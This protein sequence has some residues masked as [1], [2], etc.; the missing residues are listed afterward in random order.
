MSD[1]SQDKQAKE[2][3]EAIMPSEAELKEAD[4]NVDIL[5]LTSGTLADGGDFY[6]YVAIPPSKYQAFL[7]AEQAGNYNLA[8]FGEIL[9]SGDTLEPP[10][11][12]AKEMEEKYGA[13]PNF[14]E[15][16]VEALQDELKKAEGAGGKAPSGDSDLGVDM[17]KAAGFAEK[18]KKDKK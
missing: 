14:E 15:E 10:A 1:K 17:D 7:E 3:I 18:L 9:A 13:N 5:V 12:V 4:E 16:F 6:A 11:E 8:E 2:A